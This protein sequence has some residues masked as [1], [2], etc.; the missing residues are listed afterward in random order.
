MSTGVDSSSDLKRLR[1]KSRN[2]LALQFPQSHS[3][4]VFPQ[5]KL[6]MGKL[7]WPASVGFKCSRFYG[8]KMTFSCAVTITARLCILVSNPSNLP[9]QLLALF[10][11]EK[12]DDQDS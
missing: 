1:A 12:I 7:S 8:A 9:L 6:P 4:Q 2:S 11:G 10:T 3:E 5:R